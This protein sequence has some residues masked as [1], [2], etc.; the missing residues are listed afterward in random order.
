VFVRTF[1]FVFVQTF[2]FVSSSSPP[3]S[4]SLSV[5]LFGHLPLTSLSVCLSARMGQDD[6]FSSDLTLAELT[7]R[8]RHMSAIPTLLLFSRRASHNIHD[9]FLRES[10]SG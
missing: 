10:D 8:L 9:V 6:M 1:V 2:V 3:L 5:F 7:G 4:V